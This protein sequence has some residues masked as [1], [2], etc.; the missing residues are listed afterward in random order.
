MSEDNNN[1]YLKYLKYKKKYLDL[2]GGKKHRT[3]RNNYNSRETSFIPISGNSGL[4]TNNTN[5]S[6]IIPILTLSPSSSP[7]N[8]P[9]MIVSGP[10]VIATTPSIFVPTQR[11]T[12]VQKSTFIPALTPRTSS[13]TLVSSLS[14][15]IVSTGIGSI[16]ST[17]TV[18]PIGS[19]IVTITSQSNYSEFDTAFDTINK[20]FNRSEFLNK[21]NLYYNSYPI[22]T[23]KGRS[24]NDFLQEKNTLE[25]T[26]RN[27]NI[28]S[29]TGNS[30]NA[31]MTNLVNLRIPNPLEQ[32]DLQNLIKK[33]VVLETI[34]GILQ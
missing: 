29:S 13:P 34:I 23:Y 16:L 6:P 20:I 2:V 32:L 19:K 10:S 9:N 24:V 5:S 22:K 31:M 26:L 25:S 1:Y 17:A 27:L 4:I 33:Y 21:F 12:V 28:I 18:G 14:P 7:T 8:I 11:P 15:A 30:F 3:H